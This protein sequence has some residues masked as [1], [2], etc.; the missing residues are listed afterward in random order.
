M[1][2]P[3]LSVVVPSYQQR[4]TICEQLIA[5]DAYLSSIVPSYEIILVV[6]GDDGT[7]GV[8]NQILTMPTLSV[9][10][11]EDNQGKGHAVRHGLSMA[12]GEIVAFF[13]SGGDI[14]VSS[15]S[16]MLQ[17]LK[18]HRADIVIGSKRHSLS[19]VSY[20][21]IRRLYSRVY[22]LLNRMLFRLRIR[23]TQVGMKVFRREV[24]GAVLPRV[25]VKRFAFDLELLVVAHHLGYRRIVE[26]PVTI[27]HNFVSSVNLKTVIQTLWDTLAVFYRLRIL[28]WYDRP[29]R[30]PIL[31]TSS[32]NEAQEKRIHVDAKVQ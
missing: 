21:P 1:E 14:D 16:V 11:F 30:E 31:P 7:C 5:L 10:C 17:E 3:Y 32:H 6:D 29:I 15:L 9:V 8:V 23:D 13:D 24:L 28:G 22:Q 4:R 18:L 20:P 27:R 19:E 26:A 12:Q 25:L 2:R